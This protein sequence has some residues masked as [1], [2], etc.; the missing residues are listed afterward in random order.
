MEERGLLW[1]GNCILK[2]EVEFEFDCYLPC[3][4]NV[5]LWLITNN[6]QNSDA[7][8]LALQSPKPRIV[9]CL[10]EYVCIKV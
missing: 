4:L 2:L 6:I 8:I 3:F 7:F 1:R 10:S 9:V 5:S